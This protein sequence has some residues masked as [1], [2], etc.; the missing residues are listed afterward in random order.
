MGSSSI[1]WDNWLFYNFPKLCWAIKGVCWSKWIV[2]CTED[3]RAAS[4]S[5]KITKYGVTF[6]KPKKAAHT[7]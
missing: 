6:E 2:Y 3:E 5:G 4:V 1:F 7:V